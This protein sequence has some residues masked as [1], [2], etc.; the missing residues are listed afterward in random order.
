MQNDLPRL[1]LDTLS[2]VDFAIAGEASAINLPHSNYT[3]SGN[4]LDQAQPDLR[5]STI[6]TPSNVRSVT[7]YRAISDPLMH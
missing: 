2:V 1:R 5:L 6:Q 7:G 4:N 3:K